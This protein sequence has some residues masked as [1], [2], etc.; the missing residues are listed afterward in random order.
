[1]VTTVAM[2]DDAPRLIYCAD[3]NKRFAEIAI[4][5]GFVY[6]AQVPNTV[7]YAPDFCDQNWRKPDRAKYMAAL[8]LYRPALATVL[9]Y[10]RA[11]QLEEVLSWTH[12][13]AQYVKEAVI[14][15][16]KAQNTLAALPREI[17]G[18]EVRLGYSVPTRFAGT[19]VPLWEFCG[20]PVHLLGGSPQTQMKLTQYLDNVKSA[21]GNYAMKM[22]NQH[23]AFY[24]YGSMARYARNSSWPKLNECGSGWIEND[25]PYKAFELS[26]INIRAAWNGCPA[27]VRYAH[28]GDLAAIKKIA[29]Q[30][31]SELGYVML[32]ALREAIKRFEL[33][34][35]FVG[36]EIVG[37]V[38]FR[39]RRDGWHTVYE[40][41]AHRDWQKRGIGRMLLS[42]VPA[43]VRLK[44]TIDNAPANGFYEAAGMKN[45]SREPG[46]KRE[47][48]VWERKTH[49]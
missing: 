39:T 38:H 35:A 9:D 33:Y 14:I 34:V 36:A 17:G 43:P 11:D 20:W 48:Y 32:P 30:Y 22:A 12:E 29:N 31:K 45:I 13:A 42:A 2:S 3:G 18:K 47:L 16:P 26:C 44:C 24:V 21:D 15:I 10:E 46:R 4:R 49:G 7:Y 19:Q 25:V 37:F 41:A 23:N 28:V 1:M 5:H 6:G 40:L 27:S 8:A